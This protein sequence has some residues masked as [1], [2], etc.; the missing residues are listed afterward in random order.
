M[1]NKLI[2]YVSLFIILILL[3]SVVFNQIC[4]FNIAVPYVFI[5]FIFRLPININLNLLFLL[6]FLLGFSVDIFS[7]TLGMNALACTLIA[8]IRKPVYS[9]FTPKDDDNDII[10]PSIKKMG[11]STYILYAGSLS[12]IYCCLINVIQAFSFFDVIMLI[13]RSVASSILT[14]IIIF[15]IE[16]LISSGS[17]KRL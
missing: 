4:L 6:S 9:L 1:A 8:A 13:L 15:A 7:D 5:F 17:E 12:F 11:Y 14:I 16:S 2:G 10:I 3:Q